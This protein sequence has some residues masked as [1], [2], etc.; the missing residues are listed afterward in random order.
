MFNIVVER[1]IIYKSET[2]NVEQ[3]F[4][5]YMGMFLSNYLQNKQ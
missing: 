3:S 5:K 1:N 4:N 2:M